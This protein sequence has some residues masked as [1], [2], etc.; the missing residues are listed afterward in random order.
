VSQ[1]LTIGVVGA[2][3]LARM[4]ALAGIPLGHSFVFLDPAPDACAGELGHLI[5]ADWDD[6]TAAA[7]L[8]QCDRVTCDFENVPAA[9][10]AGLAEQTLTRPHAQ[11]LAVAQDRLQEKTFLAELGLAVAPFKAVDQRPD[12]LA[13]LDALGLPAVLKTRRLGYDGKGQQWLF[14]Q[15]DLEPA[16][17]SLA[18]QALIL[19]GA[20]AFTHE[21]ALTAVRG[22]DGSVRCY[23]LSHTVH[24]HG[25]LSAALSPSSVCAPWQ[26]DAEN[27]ITRLMTALDYV[28]VL[29][30]EFFVTEQGLVVNE[31][32]PRVHNSAHWS[33]EGALCSQFENHVRAIADAPLG[34]TAARG[35][36][37][38]V[39]VIGQW[40]D[41]QAL[42]AI[43]GLHV[44][45]YA[46][47]P[48]PGRKVGHVTLNTV[49][50][51][52]GQWQAGVAKLIE[53]GVV[54]EAVATGLI[55]AAG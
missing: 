20:V 45:D 10:M 38:M 51:S 55:K 24:E 6:T 19:E 23:P 21:C 17:Q 54:Q 47:M 44:H 50:L 30:V 4:M 22:A 33:I 12:L 27:Q 2:G 49:G 15:E 25:I 9:V 16:W 46:K 5:T 31:I 39:N 32:A 36:S 42:L 7:E 53:L 11:A 34:E 26:A 35:T 28:G 8:A 37:L 52:S 41:R 29:T 13:A 40:P 48:R 14:D 43:A 1:P 3:Q 18:G